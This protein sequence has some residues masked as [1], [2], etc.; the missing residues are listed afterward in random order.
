M[1]WYAKWI[2]PQTDTGD[3]CPLFQNRTG[4]E[5]MISSLFC[6]IYESLLLLYYMGKLMTQQ[7]FFSG[8]NIYLIIMRNRGSHILFRQR[9]VIVN[10]DIAEINMLFCSQFMLLIQNSYLY[11]DCFFLTV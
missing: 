7:I 2:K 5:I 9:R 8:S 1:E 10:M 4:I 6:G 3:V 11:S